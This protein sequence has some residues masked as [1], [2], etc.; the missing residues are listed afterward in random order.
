MKLTHLGAFALLVGLTP[1]C[2]SNVDVEDG[3][4]GP[5]GGGDAATSASTSVST[6]ASTASTASTTSTATSSSTGGGGGGG[7][8]GQGGGVSA[9]CEKM[10]LLTLS[11]AQLLEAG[12]DLVWSP[13]EQATFQ[14]T[15]TNR[16]FEDNFDY[17]GVAAT[18][19]H[20]GVG[21]GENTLFGIF[22]ADSVPVTVV[23]PAAP[24]VPSGTDVEITF[25]VTALNQP[26][27]GLASTAG[28]VTIE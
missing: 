21:V 24:D 11:D 14:V 25:T 9:I 23:L 19:D 13:G 10:A 8:G 26:C 2:G 28:S 1:A 6:T 17:P 15:M 18:T 20:P 5:E 3:G 4:G 16:S 12:G 22:G 27:E 7:E